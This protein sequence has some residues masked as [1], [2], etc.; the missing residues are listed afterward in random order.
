[1]R[2]GGVR[3]ILKLFARDVRRLAR[4]PV[5]IIVT[6]GVCVIPSLY[7]WYCIAANWDPYANTDG[8]RV[9]VSNEDEGTD[10]N[11][12]GRMD[13]GAQVVAALRDNHQLGWTFVSSEEAVQ[14]VYAGTYFA[15]II[16]PPHF[17]A[18]MVGAARG[19]ASAPQ[20]QYYVN[21]EQNAVAPKI[22]DAGA[23]EVERQVNEAFVGTLTRVVVERAQAEGRSV[24]EAE[25]QAEGGLL[26]GVDQA[27]A[28][29][30]QM[31][32]SLAGAVS[33]VDASKGAAA[34]ARCTLADVQAQL[35]ELSCSLDENAALL[36]Q[37]RRDAGAYTAAATDAIERARTL[38][39]DASSKANQSVGEAAGTLAALKGRVDS[40][41]A[42]AE[43]L[44]S[45]SQQALDELRRQAADR[46]ELADTL[47]QLESQ[48]AQQ[49][50]TLQALRAAS[51]AL[52]GAAQD[53][54]NALEA[55]TQAAQDE[56]GVLSQAQRSF[57]TEVAPQ[58][59]SALDSL[60]R[61][62]GTLS[63]AVAGL[64]TAAAN[65]DAATGQL[66]NVLDE[67]GQALTSAD[68]ALGTLRDRLARTAGDLTALRGSAASAGLQTLL[69][70][71]PQE[72]GGFMTSPVTLRTETIYPVNTYGA[73]V[74]PFYT[75]LAL[76][77]GGLILVTIFKLEVDREGEG[78]VS[79]AQGYVGRWLLLGTLGLV[80]AT[81][82]CAGDLIMGVQ[83]TNVAAFMGAGLFA[84]FVYVGL[85]YALAVAFRHIGKAVAVV[86]LIMQI[87]GSSGMYPVQMM[88]GFF[89][90]VHPFLPFTYGID[91]LREAIGGMYGAHYFIDL[92]YLALFLP[93]ALLVGLV[94]RPYLLNVNLLFDRKL[95]ETDV[96]V[97]E[98][99]EGQ[100]GGRFR[101]R[102]VVRALLDTADYRTALLARV[103]RFDAGYPR[104]V[105]TGFA[106][107]VGLSACMAVLMMV[108]D[109]GPNGKIV[110]LVIWI[111]LLIAVSAFLIVV[112]YVRASLNYQIRLS[113]LDETE[114]RS[115]A[116]A[117]VPCCAKAP[118][119][120][121]PK[122]GDA[123]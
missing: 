2:S 66:Q 76:W 44:A 70:I 119:A 122:Q 69:S 91:A 82:V 123:S 89:Q 101:L 92:G 30:D 45:T 52:A 112:E 14:G 120:A 116:R 118:A 103:A 58:L 73:G 48:V 105:R 74:A 65:A 28:A 71:N 67:A 10:N 110:M 80:Q 27:L 68:D 54:A 63:Q 42:T 8:I 20:L 59:A 6:L 11:L 94:A 9:A 81:I 108:L 3:T 38:V 19:E 87:P 72:A 36:D 97:G 34:E 95:A 85:I 104:L 49:E 121:P 31:R 77:V 60:S 7:A 114:M 113:T 15:A 18:D 64:E 79:A 4:N 100:L 55:A 90:A 61:A 107:L 53:A 32:E 93:V 98:A 111:A 29:L 50:A 40:A 17:S 37:A 24:L 26:Q 96:L 25:S 23:S 41:L 117:H 33:T 115:E 57:A 106:L 43:N 5:A 83:C 86:L 62:T 39:G 109:V 88:S 47:A 75:N 16:I 22:T 84:S 12:T 13:A 102:T 35:P 99:G 78:A 21:E 51:D 46:P 56:A 1:M